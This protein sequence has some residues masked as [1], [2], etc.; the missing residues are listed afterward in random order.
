MFKLQTVDISLN[1]SGHKLYRQSI[2]GRRHFCQCPWFRSYPLNNH[3]FFWRIWDSQLER[4]LNV[5]FTSMHVHWMF[6]LELITYSLNMTIRSPSV[7]HCVY[8]ESEEESFT[9]IRFTSNNWLTQ[10]HGRFLYCFAHWLTQR[11]GLF[12]SCFAHLGAARC[13]GGTPSRVR[14]HPKCR[15]H[16]YLYVSTYGHRIGY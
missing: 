7:L 12:L 11:H 3:Y 4:S 15:F 8:S 2:S 10:W 9:S 14:S 6:L 5:P 16:A 1:A 13:G